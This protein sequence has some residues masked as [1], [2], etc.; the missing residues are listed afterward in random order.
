MGGRLAVR[1]D[2]TDPLGGLTKGATVHVLGELLRVY[3]GADLV[4]EVH[5]VDV[6]SRPARNTWLVRMTDGT[7]W[8]AV[9]AGGCSSCGH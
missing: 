5:G 8:R 9:R 3:R 7:E 1:A 2:V 4:A 6:L